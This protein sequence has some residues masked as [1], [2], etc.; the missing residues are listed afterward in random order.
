MGI[1]GDNRYILQP[2]DRRVVWEPNESAPRGRWFK[3]PEGLLVA[4][5]GLL[6]R[7]DEDLTGGSTKRERERENGSFFLARRLNYLPRASAAA[8]SPVKNQI[9][10]LGG[11]LLNFLSRLL[12]SE[13]IGK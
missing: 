6:D 11:L 4:F 12:R 1:L 3:A 13:S 5:S 7:V 9:V 8:T 2:E 10:D